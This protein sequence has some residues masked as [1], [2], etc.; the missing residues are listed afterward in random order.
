MIQG[1]IVMPG[2][3]CEGLSAWRAPFKV[4][5]D[6]RDAERIAEETPREHGGDYLEIV[7]VYV[8]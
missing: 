3:D 1:W 5:T 7:E 2:V 8:P 6:K 4:Y